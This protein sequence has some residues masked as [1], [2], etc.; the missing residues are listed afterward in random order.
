MKREFSDWGGNILAFAVVLATNVLSN[1]L[2]FNDQNQAEIAAKYSSLFTP[3]GFTFSIWGIIYLALLVF[4]IYQAL[5][6]QRENEPIARL[7]VPFKVN[8]A[9]NA[10]W[11]YVWH[12]DLIFLSLVIM[13]VILA[14]LVVIYRQLLGR[15]DSASNIEKI[16][17]FLPFSLYT[18]WITVATIANASILQNAMGW[19]AILINPVSWALLKLGLAGAIAATVVLRAGDV[20]FVLVVAW[21]CYGISVAQAPTPAVAGAA[22]LLSIIALLLAVQ[23]G[24]FQLRRL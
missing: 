16:A 15:I 6:S 11:L 22:T 3:A 24:A 5:P 19:D 14:T 12:H 9:A 2:P 18:S 8:C 23:E 20:V 21:A 4:V 10:A 13:F 17:V 7:S 1:A